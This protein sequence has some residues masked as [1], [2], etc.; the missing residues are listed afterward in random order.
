MAEVNILAAKN[1][2]VF[3][4]FNTVNPYLSQ[5]QQS[6]KKVPKVKRLQWLLLRS[7]EPHVM[8]TT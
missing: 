3:D 7:K 2:W 6:G 1:K 8:K 5:Y 4:L